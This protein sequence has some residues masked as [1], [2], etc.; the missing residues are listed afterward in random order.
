L[1]G[2]IS[3]KISKRLQTT[4]FFSNYIFFFFFLSFS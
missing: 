4:F 3:P 1:A 2:N